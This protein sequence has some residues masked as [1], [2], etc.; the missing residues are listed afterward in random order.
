MLYDAPMFFPLVERAALAL[1]GC[2]VAVVAGC[3]GGGGGGGG[4]GDGGGTASGG[5]FACDGTVNGVHECKTYGNLSGSQV[6][7]Y[8]GQ[9]GGIWGASC[10]TAKLLGTC[11]G[12]ISGQPDVT[13]ESYY[14]DGPVNPANGIDTLCQGRG[15][16]WKGGPTVGTCHEEGTGCAVPGDPKGVLFQCTG[17]D[18]PLTNM[19]STSCAS[20][21]M[22]A[23]GGAAAGLW[24]CAI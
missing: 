14:Q 23:D 17:S 7:I 21:S 4:S 19:Q 18:T 12:P 3:G 11:D 8:Q 5:P 24:C 6:S 13:A 2:L 15:G 1:A 10:P 22:G 20:V 9:C 16:T